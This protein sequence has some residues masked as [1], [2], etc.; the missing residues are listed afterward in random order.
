ME[1]LSKFPTSAQNRVKKEALQPG[2]RVVFV[3]PG[4]NLLTETVNFA[5][6]GKFPL[7]ALNAITVRKVVRKGTERLE[8]MYAR[9]VPR[10]YYRSSQA[11]H[12]QCLPCASGTDGRTGA[13][14]CPSGF[15][16]MPGRKKEEIRLDGVKNVDNAVLGVQKPSGL[17]HMIYLA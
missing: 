5:T 11:T 7:T 13:E 14:D 6:I 4:G 9:S 15:R 2:Y 10:S 3:S 12:N 16:K 8:P 17:V 1:K